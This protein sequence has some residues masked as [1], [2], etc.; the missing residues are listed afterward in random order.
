M[1]N[2]QFSSGEV[3]SIDATTVVVTFDQYV[4][5]GGGNLTLAILDRSPLSVVVEDTSA[6]IS[7]REQGVMA[8]AVSDRS[9]AVMVQDGAASLDAVASDE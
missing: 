6:V 3:G 1:S 4:M 5:L 8:V 9:A 2:P 7:L